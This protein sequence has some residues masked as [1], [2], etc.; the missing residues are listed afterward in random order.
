MW[1]FLGRRKKQQPETIDTVDTPESI[2]TAHELRETIGHL[3]TLAFN[4]SVPL[5]ARETALLD[6][7]NIS[8]NQITNKC[9]DD[10]I[11]E[12][13]CRSEIFNILTLFGHKQD[14]L[15]QL[16]LALDAIDRASVT[17]ASN[18]IEKIGNL[19]ESF[20]ERR[21]FDEAELVLRKSIGIVSTVFGSNSSE[22]ANL[23]TNLANVLFTA[24]RYAEAEVLR[25]EELNVRLGLVGDMAQAQALLCRE[26]LADA[27]AAQ[28]R[29]EEATAIYLKLYPQLQTYLP[30]ESPG[31]QRL[32]DK[33]ER[34]S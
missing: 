3:R 18:A 23:L 1:S 14:A 2:K 5:G 21:M 4:E 12:S 20:N 19:A 32:Q 6:M 31:L 24:R 25:R 17:D 9:S 7:V 8:A 26:G 30:S 28:G 27:I 34:T 33:I 13:V 11:T 29:R 15:K 16:H 22:K 10:P